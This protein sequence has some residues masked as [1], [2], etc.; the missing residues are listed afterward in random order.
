MVYVTGRLP[1]LVGSTIPQWRGPE[2]QGMVAGSPGT[3][4]LDEKVQLV[5]PDTD[6]AS[7]MDPV[8]DCTAVELA[9][10][11]LTVGL[12]TIACADGTINA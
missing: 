3:A 7:E 12:A 4:F 9:E 2:L 8:G 1:P 11:P 5:A 6:A 10:N